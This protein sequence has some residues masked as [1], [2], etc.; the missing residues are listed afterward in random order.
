[1]FHTVIYTTIEERDGVPFLFDPS[2]YGILCRQVDELENAYREI[3]ELLVRYDYPVRAEWIHAIAKRGASGFSE[4]LIEDNE[5]EAMRLKVPRHIAAQWKRTATQEVPAEV[6]DQCD[7]IR[8][9]IDRL[10]DGI[11]APSFGFTEKE[12]VVLDK[13]SCK[14]IIKTACSY[15]ISDQIKAEAETIQSLAK[16]LRELEFRGINAREL[17]T[18]YIEREEVPGPLELYRDIATR[19]HRPGCLTPPDL[20]PFIMAAKIN[21]PSNT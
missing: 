9:K 21:Q 2:R 20:T 15:E 4:V 5:R 8:E 19:R 10:S 14:E 18:K 13:E 6:W 11:P 1:M 12:G 17:V 7:Q 16:Q 3:R